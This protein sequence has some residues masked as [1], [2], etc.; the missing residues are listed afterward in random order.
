MKINRSPIKQPSIQSPSNILSKAQIKTFKK[1]DRKGTVF[2]LIKEA[3]TLKNNIL[4]LDEERSNSS[5]IQNDSSVQK[6]AKQM[7][8]NLKTSNKSNKQYPTHKYKQNQLPI[9]TTSKQILTETDFVNN[10]DEYYKRN[11]SSNNFG[12]KYAKHNF[13]LKAFEAKNEEEFIQLIGLNDEEKDPLKVIQGKKIDMNLKSDKI[14]ISK[15]A[16]RMK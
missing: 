12:R 9:L 11:L 15:E 7:K 2:H 6:S 3:K 14:N 1:L 13:T 10:R 4:E 16:F 8:L 5:K